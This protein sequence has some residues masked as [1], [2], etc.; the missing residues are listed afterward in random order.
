[1]R[2]LSTT[3]LV[4]QRFPR[5]VGR[6]AVLV[7][8]ALGLTGCIE[9]RMLFESD[10]PGAR[11]FVDGVEIGTTPVRV[12]FSHYGHHTVVLRKPGFETLRTEVA[13]DAPW[14]LAF[15][16]DFIT[17]HFWWTGHV[18]E[19]PFS[20]TLIGQNSARDLE[21]FRRL[22]EENGVALD[23]PAYERLHPTES[24]DSNNRKATDERPE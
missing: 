22:A 15:P 14:Y 2:N 16:F 6:L 19:H 10:P 13:V 5:P 7:C 4:G 24:S 11:T 8:L 12:D 1:M 18:D 17:E 3:H 9:R 23:V 21:P 20:F